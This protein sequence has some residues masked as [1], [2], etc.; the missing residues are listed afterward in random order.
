MVK[1]LFKKTQIK[2]FIKKQTGQANVNGTIMKNMI[3][4]VPPELEIARIVIK[5]D[6]L[7]A[8]CDQLKES[9]QQAQKTQIHLTDAV[10]ENAL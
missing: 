4:A 2:P 5:V 7:M 10:V 9:L 1:S 8:L 6:E 3:V